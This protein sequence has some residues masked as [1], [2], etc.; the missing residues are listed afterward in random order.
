[1]AI[2]VNDHIEIPE[3][4]LWFT[5]SRSG[6]PGGQHVNTTSSKI[7]LHWV[8]SSS[9][10]LTPWQKDRILQRLARRINKDGELTLDVEEHRS[11]L[12]NRE[13]AEERLA[14]WIRDAL[15]VEKKRRPTRP[16]KGSVERRLKAKRVTSET[17]ARR[18][19]V[20]YE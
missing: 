8:P 12:R 18:G 13:I 10:V 11:Q 6:G 7:T 16:T 4:E 20:D 17:K 5:A 3:W 2:R 1:M 15:V 19:K 9:S 14:Q